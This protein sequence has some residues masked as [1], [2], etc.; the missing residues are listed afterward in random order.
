[1]QA[2]SDTSSQ[3]LFQ[4]ENRIYFHYGNGNCLVFNTDNSRATYYKW[5]L[6]IYAPCYDKTNER[7]L[8]CD[9]SRRVRVM[10]DRDE[11]TDDGASIDWETESKDF[12]LQTR[13]HFP[14]WIKY[15]VD[16]TDATSVQGKIILQGSTH[17]THSITDERN[18]NYRLI[19]TGNGKRCSL[20][21]SG[22]GPATVYAAEME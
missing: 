18:T 20:R 17:Q 5:D 8:A 14:R 16:A 7:F 22:T 15:D 10:E 4:Y 12:I 13:A 19:N 21:I 9:A 11:T 2:V 3:W 6:Q 1:M